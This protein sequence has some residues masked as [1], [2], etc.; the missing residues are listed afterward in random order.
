MATEMCITCAGTLS[1][2][3]ANRE[4]YRRKVVSVR[5]ADDFTTEL[6]LECGHVSEHWHGLDR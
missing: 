3:L 4:A 6:T 1:V 5:E 2:A